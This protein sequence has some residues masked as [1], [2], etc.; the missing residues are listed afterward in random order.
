M[1]LLLIQAVW[2]IMTQAQATGKELIETLK[3]KPDLITK[4]S[5]IREHEELNDNFHQPNNREGLTQLAYITPWNNKGY[6][7]AEKTAHKLTHVSPVWFQAK[8]SKVDGKLITCKIEGSHDIDRDWLERLREKNEKIKIVPRILFDGWSAD[9]MKDLLMNSQLSRSCFVDIANFYS[10]NQ[11]EGAIV[12]IYMQALISVQSLQIKEF[13]IESMQDLSKQFKKLHMELI[14]T[15][16]APLEWNNQP[17]N[18]VTPDEFKKLTEVSDFVQIMTYDYHGNKPAGVAPYDWFENCVFYL[19]TGPK[20]LA[21]LN[22]YGYEFS[23][24]KME[25]VTSDRYLKVLKSD[26]TT[27]SFDET[28]MEHKL[29]TPTSVIYY[30]T[31]TSLELRI[32]MAHRY[33]M[34]IAI[35]D[36]G[37]GLDYF[38]NLLI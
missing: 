26:Q 25:A 5:I 6:S 30:P 2:I 27:L 13:V 8:A 18:L 23:K 12:E 20:T 28:S 37:Q 33:E 3:F 11:F 36:Y 31:L 4:A 32:N 34:G 35:W 29:K 17:N 7:L 1:K 15:V 14:L 10:R 19:G 24:G 21:G 38:S 16:P 22:Y 9:D